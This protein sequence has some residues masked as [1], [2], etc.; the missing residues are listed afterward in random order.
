[1]LVSERLNE[2]IVDIDTSPLLLPRSPLAVVAEQAG[3]AYQDLVED[4]LAGARLRAHGR[5]HNRRA[6]QQAVFEGLDRRQNAVREAH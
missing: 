3:I 2:T 6:P 1:M 5:R 4:I